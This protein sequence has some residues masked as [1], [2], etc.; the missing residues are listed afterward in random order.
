MGQS[1]KVVLNENIENSIEF[2][3]GK[4]MFTENEISYS[5]KYTINPCKKTNGHS[6]LLCVRAPVGV[7]NYCNREIA[8]GRG[9]CSIEPSIHLDL[10]YLYFWLLY[11]NKYFIDKSTGS[12]FS[13]ITIGTIKNAPFKYCSLE[14]Q[15]EIIIQFFR[16]NKRAN[17]IDLLILFKIVKA[18]FMASTIFFCSL[19]VWIL[20]FKGEYSEIQKRL[21]VSEI[22]FI[23]CSL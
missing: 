16:Y 8:I 18:S 21:C 23:V 6:I 1:P 14:I 19:I 20:T 5:N 12:T 15:H 10:D 17:H 4:L 9:L 11:L 13:A 2:H 22:I 7:L 3:Q